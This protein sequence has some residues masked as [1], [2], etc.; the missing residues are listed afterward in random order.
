MGSRARGALPLPPTAARA[1]WARDEGSGSQV[2]GERGGER[3][4]HGL[5][6]GPGLEILPNVLLRAAPPENRQLCVLDPV[7][8]PA[9]APKPP[10]PYLLNGEVNPFVVEMK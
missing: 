1:T 3:K 6:N 5:E 9:L 2:E 10:L 7:T 4:G 8:V